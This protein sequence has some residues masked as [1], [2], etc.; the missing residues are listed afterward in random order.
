MLLR[1]SGTTAFVGRG[2]TINIARQGDRENIPKKSLYKPTG[3]G[4]LPLPE[5][6]W[7]HCIASLQSEL[8]PEQFNTWIRPLQLD[9]QA[10]EIAAIRST[11]PRSQAA[12][13]QQEVDK[14]RLELERRQ[15]I[16][17]LINQQ[18]LGNSDGFSGQLLALA[19]QHESN[20]SLLTF[21][22]HAGGR[23]F[24]FTG[25]AKSAQA[26][27]QYLQRLQKEKSFENTTFGHMAVERSK[28]GIVNFSLSQ[29]VKVSSV[30]D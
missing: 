6:I 9:N 25:R 20:I 3:L 18:N 10:L 29:E 17:Q 22:L 5:S 1:T 15:R 27:P 12:I 7:N 23:Q 13:I 26:V 19:R 11:L 16:Y 14:L 21:N 4:D 8:S 28:T 2:Y 30:G 24:N